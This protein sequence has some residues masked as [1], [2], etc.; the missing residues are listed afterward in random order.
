MP[1]KISR[2]AESPVAQVGTKATTEGQL[3]KAAITRV[4]PDGKI[5]SDLSGIGKFLLNP[6]SWEESKAANWVAT[7]VP[8][9]SDPVMQWLSSGPRSVSFEALVTK[10][11]SDSSKIYTIPEKKEVPKDVLGAIAGAFF[12]IVPE[13]INTAKNWFEAAKPVA[14][15]GSS[16]SDVNYYSIADQLNFFRSLLYPIYDDKNSPKALRN[17]PPLVVLYVGDTFS[18]EGPSSNSL[19]SSD[20][21]WVVTNL[22]IRVTKQLPNLSPMEASVEFQLVQ[23]NIKSATGVKFW[24]DA[25]PKF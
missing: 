23:Y 24:S 19:T 21:V 1:I 12:K 6:T 2:S 4:T 3:Y 25:T 18:K 16:P 5:S 22:R 15:Q 17:S 10:D 13:T 8:G 9:Q 20:D 7:Q 14:Q 11:T